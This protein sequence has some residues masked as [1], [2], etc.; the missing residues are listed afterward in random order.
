[1]RERYCYWSVAHG[2]DV[3]MMQ[4]LV[5][6]ARAVGVFKDF[7]VWTERL[8]EGAVCHAHR[9]RN[10]RGSLFRLRLLQREVHKLNYDYFVWLDPD[11][12]FVRPPG[13]VLRVLQGSPVHASLESDASST[14]NVPSDWCGCSLTNY[15]TLMR[16]CGVRSRAIFTVDGGFWVVHHD[17][18]GTFCELAW[19]FWDICKRA[20]YGFP[21]EPPLAY[22]THMLCG[23]P[24]AHALKKAGDLWAPDR[25]GCFA[26][27]LPNGKEWKCVDRLTGE[28][29]RVNPAIIHLMHSSGGPDHRD[30]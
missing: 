28:A 26:R 10:A 25:T 1:M 23:N 19:D 11:T 6:S 18:I 7:H 8:I 5:D 13:K 27:A 21:L 30:G 16:F 24:Y 22:A 12:Y 29:F 2:P 4:G 20:G 14:R 3:D 9:R 15:T 17:V